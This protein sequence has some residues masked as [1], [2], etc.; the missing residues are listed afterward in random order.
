MSACLGLPT[1]LSESIDGLPCPILRYRILGMAPATTP[2]RLCGT[3]TSSRRGRR[4]GSSV[5]VD[6]SYCQDSLGCRGGRYT[7]L[8]T[9]PSANGI[10]SGYSNMRHKVVEDLNRARQACESSGLPKEAAAA[11]LQ[12]DTAA[13][14]AD[15]RRSCPMALRSY[16]EIDVSGIMSGQV[17]AT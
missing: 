6:D 10:L 9:D 16:R 14:M 12:S 4:S 11:R 13:V 15:F 8:F 3:C 17:A 5:R 2:F 1:L 7:S